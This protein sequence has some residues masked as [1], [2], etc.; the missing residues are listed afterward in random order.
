MDQRNERSGARS[1]SRQ[2]NTR[3]R[4]SNP[5]MTILKVLGTLF[6]IGVLTAAIVFGIFMKYV[7]S[8]LAEQ[9]YI[10][11]SAYTLK[12]TSTVYCQDSATGEWIEHQKLYRENRTLVDFEK[13]PKHVLEALVAIED[14][15]FYTHK[16][17]DWR[18]TAHAVLNM[19][20]GEQDTFG[21]STITQQVIKNLTTENQTTVKRKVTEIF[22]AL[23]FEKNYTKDDILEIYLNTVY[24][25]A[26]AYGIQAA[27]E[28]YFGKDVSELT[29]AE[30]ACIVGITRYPYMYDPSRGDWY[31]EKNRERQLTVLSEMLRQEKITQSQYDA[32]VAEEMVFTWD[33]NFIASVEADT[34]GEAVEEVKTEYN[35]YFI[36]QV[37]R[38]VLEDLM[39]AGLNMKAAY[40]LIYEGG[41]QIYTTL[42]PKIQE[43]VDNVYY[44]VSNLDITSANGQQLQSAITVMDPYTGNVVAM[45]GGIGEKDG[46]LVLNRA[47]STRP[48][49]SAI[50]PLS[51]YAPALD[52]GVITPATVTDD[53]PIELM[54]NS[55]GRMVAYPLNSYSRYYGLTTLQTA[56]RQSTNT[57]AMRTLMELTVPASYEFM[58]DKLGFTTLV[59]GDLDRAPL[60]L[61]GLTVGVSTEEMAAAYSTFV[62]S[63]IYNRP[64][65]YT[66]VKDRNGNTLLENET[67]SWVAMKESTA[68]IMNGL[69]SSVVSSGTG[70]S[71]AF[72]GM[73]IAGKTGTTNNNYDRYFVGYTPYYCASVWIGYDKMEK[74]KA[75]GNPA[76]VLWKK[77]M[78][79]VHEDLPN[80]SFPTP[81]S[82]L[83]SATVC[84]KSGL[85]ANELCTAAG[86]TQTVT[87]ASGTEPSELCSMHIAADFCTAGNCFASEFCPAESIESRIVLDYD[88]PLIMIEGGGTKTVVAEDGTEQTITFDAPV[89]AD[90]DAL[91]LKLI[92]SDE[93]CPAHTHALNEEIGEIDPETGLPVDP[94]APIDPNTPIEP[95][96][97][98]ESTDPIIPGDSVDPIEKDEPHDDGYGEGDQSSDNLD[99]ILGGE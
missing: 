10:D 91:I 96:D 24:F 62:N 33:D 11:A 15:R 31:L 9:L 34:E 80:K 49:G 48:C 52:A 55:A 75:S 45:S 13:I 70:T 38:D 8:T 73:S 39:D 77:V 79:E 32:A 59:N 56:L 95:T 22:R 17:V 82:G 84:T 58:T 28:A 7:N 66:I 67:A 83:T 63:G 6:C 2:R 74:I 5:L 23:E 27:S 94:N 57:I 60:A 97:P 85:L 41:L 51:V 53:Y 61:G 20:T 21:G 71:A 29:I 42:D 30:G 72:S 12:Q 36:D 16:G 87:L 1:A 86:H 99:W 93:G 98:I 40:D 50:K 47:M 65:T 68:Y 43:I 26:G 78:S 69:L 46:D 14:Q 54:E 88:R 90:D 64:R 92:T 25:G 3:R 44:D 4:R 35:S 76:A 19:F 37:I 81:A 89:A 18:R